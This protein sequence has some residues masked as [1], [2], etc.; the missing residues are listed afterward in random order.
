[1]R[2]CLAS[3]TLP[4]I[5]F[6]PIHEWTKARINTECG[7]AYRRYERGLRE[8]YVSYFN[9]RPWLQD[10]S[11]SHSA[12]SMSAALPPGWNQ[13]ERLL[14]RSAI[15]P[16]ARSAKS[17]QTLSLALLG[18]ALSI[19]PSL[20]W[21]R[22]A[23]EIEWPFTD[24]TA[25]A[26]FERELS[27]SD[28]NEE[29][30]TTQLDFAAE[31][32]SCFVAIESKWCERGFDVCSCLRRSEGTHLPGGYCSERVLNRPRYWEAARDF[33]GLPPERLPLLPC[34]IAPLY[35]VLRNVAAARQL[36]GVSRAFGFVLLYD[37][38][39]PYFRPTGSW[40]GWPAVLRTHL[41][42]NKSPRF[43]F[44]AIAWQKLITRLPLDVNIRRWAR[45]KHRLY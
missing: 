4:A 22:D 10:A 7:L 43:C 45:I 1:M 33:F 42:S 36:A 38:S 26:S 9:Q 14:P 30:H 27:R 31:D 25:R 40:P 41:E 44:R 8:H 32:S 11:Q 23:F 6:A 21:F 17:S 34:Q 15:H 39:N 16:H 35:Q 12:I 19:D 3:K 28:L 13:L 20:N 2:H 37:E 29:P 18:G 24:R 5:P